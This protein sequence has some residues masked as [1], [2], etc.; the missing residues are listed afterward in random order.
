LRKKIIWSLVLV[1][2]I[3]GIFYLID[4]G[5]YTTVQKE[6][7]AGL[8]EM[9]AVEMSIE[10]YSDEAKISIKDKET[11]AK[12]IAGLSGTKLKK[13]SDF[14]SESEYAIRIYSNH[15]GNLGLEV[16]KDKKYMAI[17]KDSG[18]IKY[19][20]VNDDHHLETIDNLDWEKK[21]FK[22]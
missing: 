17:F 7:S 3:V 8:G 20:I 2:V 1:I 6:I 13:V 22:N 21:D 11:A 5:K 4:K 9:D 18:H 14:S 12:I 15:T 10:R 16:T 19:K